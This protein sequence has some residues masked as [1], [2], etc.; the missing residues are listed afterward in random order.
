MANLTRE[1]EIVCPTTNMHARSGHELLIFKRRNGGALEFRQLLQPGER[2]KT[3]L[4]E[5]NNHFIA[6]RV[7]R[8]PNLRY[9]MSRDCQTLDNTRTFKVHINLTYAVADT[10]RIVE[11][12]ER[13]PFGR[14]VELATELICDRV[15]RLDW[16]SIKEG[17]RA[18]ESEI[19]VPWEDNQGF[20]GSCVERLQWFG[21]EVGLTVHDV[22]IARTLSREHLAVEHKRIQVADQGQ[23]NQ[24]ERM[25]TVQ[26]QGF[27]QA[28]LQHQLH[29]DLMRS[30]TEAMQGIITRSAHKVEGFKGALEAQ[31]SMAGLLAGEAGNRH[32][33]PQGGPVEGPAALPA[34]GGA[35]AMLTA[36]AP[37]GTGP[38][39]DMLA[40]LG[41]SLQH[42]TH[43][44][45]DERRPLTAAL[46]HVV[47][48]ALLDEEDAEPELTERFLVQL[49]K[50]IDRRLS[51]RDF[52]LEQGRAMKRLL[53][54]DA[55]RAEL[56]G[57]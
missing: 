37:Q 21:R 46:L 54:I 39:A 43:L 18:F 2:F 17:D 27:A 45:D 7:N 32:G 23:I 48:Q 10:E 53:E 5:K 9:R 3:G 35:R 29:G 33:G 19:L 28:D 31:R 47:A 12:F 49:K 8:D 56:R 24:L 16:Q 13:D 55:V 6:F 40:F 52:N 30:S 25:L 26:Q 38:A 50:Q 42:L 36:G 41:D 51:A 57:A 4:F 14:L 11:Q 20:N 44:R 22:T 15:R 1:H 34:G